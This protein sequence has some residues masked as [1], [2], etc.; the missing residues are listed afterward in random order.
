MPM[1]IFQV[2]K[3]MKLDIALLFYSL[4]PLY[5]LYYIFSRKDSHFHSNL[6]YIFIIGVL[7]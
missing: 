3:D 2:A 6:F 4:I 7:A 1:A 5:A